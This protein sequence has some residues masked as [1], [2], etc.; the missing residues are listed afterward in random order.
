MHCKS[1]SAWRGAPDGVAT[2]KVRKSAFGALNIQ[3]LE[4][5]LNEV[6]LS[7]PQGAPW[8][9]L[10]VNFGG[11]GA[12]GRRLSAIQSV[13]RG[14]P[15]ERRSHSNPS[16]QSCHTTCPQALATRP[17]GWAPSMRS[18]IMLSPRGD[19]QRIHQCRIGHMCDS[20]CARHPAEW[21]DKLW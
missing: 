1:S 3:G 19:S 4:H 17:S 15:Q 7:P 8:R 18:N 13:E 12:G 21:C 9:T 20:R 6:K 5:L 11:G 16:L 10:W 14:K 2:L